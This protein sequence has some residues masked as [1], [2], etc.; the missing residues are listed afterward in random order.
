MFGG[1]RGRQGSGKVAREEGG[2]G[3]SQGRGKLDRH[4]LRD[5]PIKDIYLYPLDR[6]FREILTAP[7]P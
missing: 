2:T 1:K 4:N 6:R 7:G 3:S 5:K